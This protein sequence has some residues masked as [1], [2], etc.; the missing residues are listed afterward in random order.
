MLSRITSTMS[1]AMVFIYNL[2]IF[3][4]DL[5]QNTDSS[6]LC[7]HGLIKDLIKIIYSIVLLK[8][9][10]E[11]FQNQ[12]LYIK[13]KTLYTLNIF[14]L[15]LKNWLY[16]TQ[17]SACNDLNITNLSYCYFDIKLILHSEWIILTLH[18]FKYW[19]IF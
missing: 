13:T 6:C 12:C 10:N 3:H 5:C 7:F 11:N 15:N 19:S 4:V 9:K 14:W 1:T 16:K 18:M 17:L 2:L 8:R